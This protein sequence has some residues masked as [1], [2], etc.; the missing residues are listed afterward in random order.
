ME[1]KKEFG[2]PVK[3][4]FQLTNSCR[5]NKILGDAK[6]F[7]L[8]SFRR[9]LEGKKCNYRCVGRFIGDKL[10]NRQPFLIQKQ[11][12]STLQTI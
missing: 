3:S 2:F 10:H 6:N 5:W 8:N 12:H 1:I 9:R 7:Y 11:Q 4:L